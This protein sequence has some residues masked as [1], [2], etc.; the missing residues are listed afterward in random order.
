MARQFKELAEKE[1]IKWTKKADEDKARYAEQMKSYVPAEDP[2]GGRGKKKA[3]KDPNAPK[4]NMSAYF[5]YS[6]DARPTIKEQNPDASFG[7][8]ARLISSKFKEL[9]EEE[10]AAWQEKADKDKVRYQREMAAY[11]GK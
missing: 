9:S 2:T 8:I 11:T 7:D 6:I 1:K 10:K 5:L 4:R 3:K